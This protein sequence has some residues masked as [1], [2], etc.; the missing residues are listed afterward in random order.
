M[1]AVRPCVRASQG[2]ETGCIVVS[3]VDGDSTSCEPLFLFWSETLLPGR[4]KYSV[5]VLYLE[6]L[7]AMIL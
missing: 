1:L 2:H 6:T 5:R 3:G 7:L 4:G